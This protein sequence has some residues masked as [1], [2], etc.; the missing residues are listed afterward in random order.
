VSLDQVTRQAA[1]FIGKVFLGG[2]QAVSSTG[3]RMVRLT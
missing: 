2:G 1:D 3:R